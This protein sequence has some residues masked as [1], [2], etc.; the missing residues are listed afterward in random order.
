[1]TPNLLAMEALRESLAKTYEQT[2]SKVLNDQMRLWNA[3]STEDGIHTYLN[4]LGEVLNH[5]P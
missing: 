2:A 5:D 3:V 4:F 1:M